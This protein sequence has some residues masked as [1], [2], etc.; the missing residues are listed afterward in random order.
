MQAIEI[1]APIDMNGNIHLPAPYQYLYGQ[2]ARLVILL[3]DQ[4]GSQSVAT[5]WP[6]IDPSRDLSSYMG[7]AAISED[8]VAYQRRIRDSEWP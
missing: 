8:G 4:P 1:E 2:R 3:P 7:A 5:D 6:Q